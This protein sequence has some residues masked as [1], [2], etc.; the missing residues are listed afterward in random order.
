MY[1]PH[2]L[3]R[4]G[5]PVEHTERSGDAPRAT[6]TSAYQPRVNGGRRH[7]HGDDAGQHH[8]VVRVDGYSARS[9]SISFSSVISSIRAPQPH[10]Q[11]EELVT[12]SLTLWSTIRRG[13]GSTGGIMTKIGSMATG[14]LFLPGQR[15]EF[16]P[17]AGVFA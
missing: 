2:W 9:V 3:S 17:G 13:T 11:R 12:K 1:R 15:E 16:L 7:T 4:R 6:L 5:T 8:E 14:F 10:E